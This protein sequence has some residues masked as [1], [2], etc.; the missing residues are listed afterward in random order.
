M[1]VLSFFRNQKDTWVVKGILVLTA[2]SFCSF[3]GIQGMTEMRMRNRTIVKLSGKS[4]KIQDFYNA[5]YKK[6][7]TLRKLGGKDLSTDDEL[8]T[9]LML[10]TLNELASQAVVDKVIEH[11]YIT[12]TDDAVRA[13]VRQLA[14]F[15]GLDGQ[16][17]QTLFNEYLRQSGKTE[18]E[19]IKEMFTQMEIAQLAQAVRA[20]TFIPNEFAMTGFKLAQEQRD[21]DVF[22]IDPKNIK[23]DAKPSQADLK[24]IYEELSEDLMAPEYRD[25]TVM[26]LTLQD[27][28]NKIKFSD[29]ELEDYYKEHKDDFTKEEIRNLDQMLF[30][31]EDQAKAAFK[32]I[33][34]GKSFEYVAKEI[35][36]QTE[37]QTHLG[38]ITQS[39]ATVEWPSDVF[40]AKKGAVVGPVSTSFGWQIIRI[41]K[42]TPKVE[43]SFA[44]VKKEIETKLKMADAFDK[45]VD[46]SVSLDDRLG[47]GETLE[48]IAKSENLK[49]NRFKGVT[50]EGKNAKGDVIVGLNSEVLSTAFQMDEKVDSPMIEG[51]NVFY[52]VR[53]DTVKYPEL[54]TLEQ[55]KDEVVAAWKSER[56]DELARE[57]LKK[58]EK[59]LDKKTA[60]STIKLIP[61][62]NYEK[63]SN[64]K[65]DDNN[66]PKQMVYGLF[67]KA[68]GEYTIAS[69]NGKHVVARV[70][71]VNEL[72]DVKLDNKDF[73]K[74]YS[75]MLN[76]ASEDRMATLLSAFGEDFGLTIK[77]DA[78]DIAFKALRKKSVS[79]E[80]E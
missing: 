54:K 44:S 70:A 58:V 56:Q 16:F 41:N 50:Q 43:R 77:E 67:N 26:T 7:E 10:T 18:N 39:T 78:A 33:N 73:V 61:G 38:D 17:N 25:L 24:K 30:S 51:E 69:E 55:A 28:A 2:L 45:M 63:L 34:D 14:M 29:E 42:I 76:K 57:L 6:L 8:N 15:T 4:L 52:V 19:F 32:A 59:E 22:T 65:R 47:A 40:E 11:Q 71:R 1:S 37:E 60:V 12:I 80:E 36:K 64:Q 31:T 75:D 53:V 74:Q 79:E 68:V 20:T 35:A 23:V 3:F 49:L 62:I 9:S 27:V 72:K 48:E 46:L 13:A 66:L 21:F 5:Y